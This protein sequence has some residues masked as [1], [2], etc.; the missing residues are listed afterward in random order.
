MLNQDIS[1][2]DLRR[3][4]EDAYWDTFYDVENLLDYWQDDRIDHAF[5]SY[6]DWA[7]IID[8]RG[9]FDN[10]EIPCGYVSDRSYRRYRWYA[11]G[12]PV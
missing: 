7:D 8:F 5:V 1:W 2:A 12:R 10:Y 3:R 9:R 11:V 6:A 4:M